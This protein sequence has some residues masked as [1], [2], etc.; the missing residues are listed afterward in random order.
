MQERLEDIV[1]FIEDYDYLKV[2]KHPK[3]DDLSL[4]F[5]ADNMTMLN[6]TLGNVSYS[7]ISDRISFEKETPLTKNDVDDILNQEYNKKHFTEKAQEVIE[8][9]ANAKKEIVL[10]PI[11][12]KKEE[13]FSIHEK[14]KTLILVSDKKTLF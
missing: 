11:Q 8:Q 6:D 10:K 13:T 2:L 5:S 1:D 4:N 12:Y 9:S 7:G 3:A 14:Q